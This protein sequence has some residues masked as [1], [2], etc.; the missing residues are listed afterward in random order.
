M[1]DKRHPAQDAFDQN[2]ERNQSR[3]LALFPSIGTI[4][5][6][7][8][9]AGITRETVQAWCRSDRNGF[10][11]QLADAK[12]QFSEFLENLA[13]ERIQTDAPIGNRGSDVLLISLLNHH[14][15]GF[16]PT[17]EVKHE[18]G[19]RV[20]SALQRANELDSTNAGRNISSKM[21][22]GNDAEYKELP[23]LADSSDSV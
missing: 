3:F 1:N 7:C 9:A 4:S 12:L 6:T 21:L 15:P 2:V 22:P 10:R 17:V 5:K 23:Q 11:D 14:V 13:L 8:I 19:E 20:L 18:L 16:R